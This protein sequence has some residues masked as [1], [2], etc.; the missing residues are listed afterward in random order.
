MLERIHD[1]DGPEDAFEGRVSEALRE[2]AGEAVVLVG[3]RLTEHPLAADV[4]LTVAQK[5]GARMALVPRRAGDR[6]ALRAGVHRR[7]CR[8]AAA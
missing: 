7:S 4:A 2:A 1:G 6:G 3:E 8:A 5:Y